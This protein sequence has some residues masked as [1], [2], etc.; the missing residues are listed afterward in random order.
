MV[1]LQVGAYSHILGAVG[2]RATQET[3]PQEEERR[4][5]TPAPE[6]QATQETGPQATQRRELQITLAPARQAT[7]PQVT[8]APVHQAILRRAI[9]APARLDTRH[10]EDRLDIM[11]PMPDNTTKALEELPARPSSIMVTP[12]LG[13]PHLA[14]PRLP[15]AMV[16][17]PLDRQAAGLQCL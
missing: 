9:P 5:L 4:E 7:P 6:P 2:R 8:L 10:Q 12:H 11:I 14:T 1:E 17:T 16:N 3:G 13:A 15:E